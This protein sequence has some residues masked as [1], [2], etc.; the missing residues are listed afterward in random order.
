MIETNSAPVLAPI[1]PQSATETLPVTFTAVA[2]DSDNPVNTLT[3]SLAGA[4]VGADIDP[5]TGVFTWTPT[6]THGPA[7]YMFDVIVTDNGNPTL[8][9]FETITVTV[10]ELNLPPIIVGPGDQ[11]NTEGDVVSLALVANDSDIPPNTMTWSAIGLPSGLT[12]ESATG[13][14]S[15]VAPDP[16]ALSRIY[17]VTVSVDDGNGGTASASFD[18]T[19]LTANIQPSAASDSYSVVQGEMLSVA[20]PGVLANDVDPN[21]EPLTAAI[22]SAPSYGVVT[23][24]AD[25]S[26]SYMHTAGHDLDDSFTYRATDAD[27]AFDIA[28]VRIDV[29]RSN[30]APIGGVDFLTTPEDTFIDFD[31]L[32]NDSDADGDQI[33]VGGIVQPD[34]G[35]LTALPSGGYRYQPPPN[36]HGSATASYTVRDFFGGSDTAEIRITVTPVNDAPAANA[37]EVVLSTYLPTEIDVLAN[38]TDA[39]GDVLAIDSADLPDHGVLQVFGSSVTFTP[40]DGWI[41]TTTFTYTVVDPHGATDVAVVTVTLPAETLSGARDLAIEL[42]S[43]ALSIAG[44]APPFIAETVALSAVESVRLMTDAFYQTIGAFQIPF[45]F[46][47]LSLIVLVGLGGAT[48]V[49]ILLAGKVREHWAVVLLDREAVLR[50]HERPD[51]TSAVIYNYNPTTESILSTGNPKT[52]GKTTWMPVHTARGDGWA[53][54]EYLTEQVDVE[55]FSEDPRP[56]KLVHQFAERLRKGG[57]VTGLIAERGIILALT[58]PPAQ[59]APKQFT[60]LL[61]GRRLRR[62]PTVGGVLHDQKDFHLAVADPFL[63]AY[64]DTDVVTAETA[65]SKTALIPAEVWNFRYMALGENTAQP[66]LV[67]FEYQDGKPKIVGLGIDE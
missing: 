35:S 18:W 24:S 31:P 37:D 66:W 41:G 2:T 56:V 22:V 25:G 17:P 61:G 53:N 50:V 28:V 55:T 13:V 39:D 43:D 34:R 40:P 10:G 26:F 38:D 46:L 20:A 58:G 60:E 11:L 27:G 42:G 8:F 52:I 3:F 12:I 59:L 47:G 4:P 32:A 44:L 6:E 29:Q 36:F 16:G 48:K 23:L 54:A 65:H 9:D 67:F 62:L 21:A 64:D 30:V 5:V 57:D 14:I 45:L 7:I 15:G 19:V 49:P 1:G 33:V 51:E 63:A